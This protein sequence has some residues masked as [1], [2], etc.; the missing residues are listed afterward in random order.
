MIQQKEAALLAAFRTMPPEEKEILL[1]FAKARAA[2]S[3]LSRRSAFKL[4]TNKPGKQ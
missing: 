4:I 2:K 1:I 3:A